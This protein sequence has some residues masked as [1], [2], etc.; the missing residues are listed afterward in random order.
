MM[1][2]KII[3]T[4]LL[5]IWVLQAQVVTTDPAY[6]TENDHIIVYF[7]ADQGD[8]G[9]MGYSGND[10]YAHTG[11]VTDQSNGDWVYVVAG[12][13]EN[14]AK[15]KLTRVG[16]DLWQ[17]TIGNPHA[18]Y[19][20]PSSEKIL[21]LAFVFRNGDSNQSGRDIGG[22]DIFYTLYEPGLTAVFAEPQVNLNFNDPKR[23]PLF[24]HPGDTQH[25]VATAAAIGVQ[26]D[27]LVLHINGTLVAAGTEDSLV[28]DFVPGIENSGANRVTT[29]AYANSGALTDSSSFYTMVISGSN[30][31]QKPAGVQD[32]INYETSTSVTL[33]LFAPHKEFVYVIG[34]FNDWKVEDA[35][36]MYKDSVDADT[37]H[38]WLNITGLAPGQEYAFQYLVDGTIRI[39]DPYAD[40]VLDPWN[41]SWISAQTY[42]DLKAYPEGKTDQIVSVLQ[43]AQPDFNWQVTDFDKPAS[44]RLVIYELLIRDFLAAHDFQTLQDTLTYLQNLGINAIE[45]MPVTEFEGNESW[46]YNP[47]FYFAPDKY[48]GP[49]NAFKTFVDAC[50]QRGIAVIMDM[51]LNHSY[52][53]SPFVRLYNEGDYGKPTSE[54]PW[55]NVSSPNP[56]YAWGYDFNHESKATQNLVDRINR[57]WMNEYKI[58][59][60][61]FDFTKG[62]TNTPG[63]GWNFDGKRI[64]ILK[65]MANAIWAAQPGAYVILEHF[66]DNSEE[67]ILADY[68]MLVWGN[69]NYSYNEATMGYNS[70]SDF[71]WGLYQARGWSKPGL[72]TYMESH[73]EERLMYKNLEYGNHSG[74]YDIRDLNTALA[75]QKLA[76]AFF[77]TL[78]GPK[79]IWQFGELGY[80][81]SID[82]NGRVGN[83]PIRWDYLNAEQ[84]YKL[85]LTWSALLKLR[86]ENPVVTSATTTV[87]YRLA[88]SLKRINLSHGTMN[89]AII[90]NFGVTAANVSPEFQHTGNW[91]DY[92]TGD[93]VEVTYRAMDVHL[94]PGEFR[95]YT[96][97]KLEMPEGDPL[98]GIRDFAG[99]VP[100]E[101][102]LGQNYPNPFNP[103]TEIRYTV[104]SKQPLARIQVELT[105]YN[106]LGQK[107]QTL[108]NEKQAP[109]NYKIRFNAGRLASGVYFYRIRIGEGFSKI[110]KMILLR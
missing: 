85:Y 50:H 18:Y 100:S 44:E 38:Y 4:T 26:L 84:R 2:H 32:G 82:Y 54:N 76:G 1:I 52:G 24:V 71:S 14:T 83:K 35:Y 51:V 42:P 43:T 19:G 68:G 11:V 60:F 91:Y 109:G 3:L 97:Q 8:Q 95:I 7:H 72:V 37:A 39:A 101:F 36:R 61:R 9:L 110:K 65:R 96:D 75:R 28:F 86:N 74:S 94:D 23:A 105:V 58:D 16:T 98:S 25:I 77:F 106:A 108:V 22:A 104:G 66:T 12:W 89:A 27:S 107:L 56:N 46:G 21:K 64:D 6:A 59:G 10:V 67:K 34:D 102:C 93:T 31:L 87:D 63:D 73:D 53:Q 13:T 99:R 69:L 81:Y 30:V 70:N 78:P 92:F 47:S 48:Y 33:S 20:V 41:D 80:D 79:M 57:Y 55:Y 15:A 49:K 90:G 29:I 40:K 103:T 45:L 88:G 5:S 17:L 62:F